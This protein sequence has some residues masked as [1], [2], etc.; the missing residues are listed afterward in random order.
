[1]STSIPSTGASEVD[2]LRALIPPV[3]ELIRDYD[4]KWTWD[5]L[6]RMIAC[7]D[8][9]PIKRQPELRT[10]YRVWYDKVVARH[11]SVGERRAATLATF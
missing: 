7:G 5:E 3:S 8:L 10:R 4:A 11:G 9:L 1:M 2:D 6:K